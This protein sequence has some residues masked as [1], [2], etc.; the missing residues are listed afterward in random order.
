MTPLV[1]PIKTAAVCPHCSCDGKWATDSS[2]LRVVG[3][4][5]VLDLVCPQCR[6]PFELDMVTGRTAFGRSAPV[7]PPPGPTA[8]VG[9]P[10]IDHDWARVGARA[11]GG[12]LTPILD[13]LPVA[14]PPPTTAPPPARPTALVPLLDAVPAAAPK[15]PPAVPLPK[16]TPPQP[17]PTAPEDVPAMAT[18]PAQSKNGFW[19]K[20]AALPLW[21]QWGLILIVV[22]LIGVAIFLSPIPLGGSEPAKK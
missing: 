15:P 13:D 10:V 22:A 4:D 14:A 11:G 20:F 6:T 2:R 17:P 8:R 9:G 16:P 12:G 3:G 5:Q 7:G 18:S 21:Q 1:Y 19:K